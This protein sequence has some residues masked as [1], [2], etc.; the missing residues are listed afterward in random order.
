MEA[1]NDAE[2]LRGKRLNSICHDNIQRT[3]QLIRTP[4]G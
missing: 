3:R 4:N 1:L 2:R